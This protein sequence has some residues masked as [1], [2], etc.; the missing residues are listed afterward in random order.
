MRNNAVCLLSGFLAP[1]A[2]EQYYGEIE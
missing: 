1:R 2:Y